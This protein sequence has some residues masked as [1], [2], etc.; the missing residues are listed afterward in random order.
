MAFLHRRLV[1]GQI[2]LVQGTFIDNG[3]VEIP[4]GLPVVAGIML[5][6]GG[7]AHALKALH[8]GDRHGTVQIRVFR[9]VFEKP[10]SQRVPEDIDA[11]AQQDGLSQGAGLFAHHLPRPEHQ[12]RIPGR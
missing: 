9:I 4:V 10:S 5:E 8:N 2:N 12:F 3:I 11:R 7:D 1:N 6:A